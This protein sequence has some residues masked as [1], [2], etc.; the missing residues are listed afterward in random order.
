[1]KLVSSV[2]E[3]AGVPC[4]PAVAAAQQTWNCRTNERELE[5]MGSYLPQTKRPANTKLQ[6]LW[7]VLCE[8]LLVGKYPVTVE[9]IFY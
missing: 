5:T 9:C 4:G 2:D 1:M 6:S 3:M 7:K 8:S